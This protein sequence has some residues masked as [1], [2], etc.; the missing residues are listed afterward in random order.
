M[1][2]LVP[3]PGG[4]KV[5][6]DCCDPQQVSLWLQFWQFDFA[7]EQLFWSRVRGVMFLVGGIGALIA[8]MNKGD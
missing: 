4:R 8:L 7:R 6:I 3:M 1:N 5:V 2:V